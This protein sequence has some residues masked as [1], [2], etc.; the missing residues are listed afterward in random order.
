MILKY[1]NFMRPGNGF[2]FFA[3]KNIKFILT[4]LII[5]DIITM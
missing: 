1:K 3:Y 4:V 5:Y 2:I